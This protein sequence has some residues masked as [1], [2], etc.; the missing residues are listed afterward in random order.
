[1]SNPLTLSVGTANYTI[2]TGDLADANLAQ[3][4]SSAFSLAD[5]VFTAAVMGGQ[6]SALTTDSLQGDLTASNAFS[7]KRTVSS[8]STITFGVTPSVKCSVIVRKAGTVFPSSPPDITGDPTSTKTISVPAG[9]AYVSI[10]LLVSLD[11]T[12]KGEFT[13][14]SVGVSAGIDKNDTFTLANHFIFD[15]TATVRDAIQSAFGRFVL[16]FGPDITDLNDLNPGDI[17]ESEFIGSLALTASVTEGF[18]GAFLGASSKGGLSVSATS[19]LGSVLAKVNPTFKL[20]VSFEVDYTHTDAFRLVTMVQTDVVQLL[21]FKRKTND[22][23]T[24][25]GATAS[26]DP[27][28]QVNIQQNVTALLTEAANKLLAGTPIANDFSKGVSQVI[29]AATKPLQDATNDL[30]SIIPNQIKRLPSLSVNASASWEKITE[31]T[32]FGSFDFTRPLNA[33]AW[34]VAMSGDLQ[35]ALHLPGVTL[36]A[37]SYV[38]NSLTKKSTLSFSFF[39]LQAQEVDQY[40]DTVTLTYAGNGVFQF[41]EKTGVASTSNWF[42]HQKEADFYFLVEA[43]LPA[44]GQVNDEDVRMFIVRRDQNA[45]DHSAGLGKTISK[46][47]PSEGQAIALLLSAATKNTPQVPATLTAQFAAS[48][49]K[50]IPSTPFLLN[51]NPP[52]LSNQQADRANFAAFAQAVDDVATKTEDMFP[53]DATYDVWAGVSQN[54]KTGP[55]NRTVSIFPWGSTNPE[56]IF[57][58][59]PLAGEDHYTLVE[60]ANYIEEARR[61]MDLCDDLRQLATMTA[62]QDSSSQFNNVVDSITQIAKNDTPIF[63]LDFLNGALLALV[64]RMGANPTSVDGPQQTDLPLKSFDVTITYA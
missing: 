39:G 19:K 3:Q 47:L 53:D 62:D 52:P 59:T 21:I 46:L 63:L 26:I 36:G 7:W 5:N 48:A 44:E 40:F 2:N 17:V 4:A 16:P 60:I 18:S 35:S 43:S 57:Q 29:T 12:A 10:I 32:V 15:Q 55:P 20:G 22:L 28:V 64:R 33:T 25:L 34:K 49:F 51:G 61:F 31:N 6:I 1:M 38:E 54:I 56:Q 37:G 27:G 50:K 8:S 42:G 14:G 24:S 11:V 58:N 9:K 30:N 13:S 41:R 45:S 23:K